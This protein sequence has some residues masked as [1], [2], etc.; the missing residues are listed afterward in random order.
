MP[1]WADATALAPDN[2]CIEAFE[3]PSGL[4]VEW[5]LRRLYRGGAPPPPHIAAEAR[6]ERTG[7]VLID[8]KSG[9]FRPAEASKL[10]CGAADAPTE[11]LGPH[12]TPAP[13]TLAFDRIGER[14]F[15]LK[16]R[17]RPGSVVE[18]VLEAH[19]ARD[20]AALWATPLLQLEATRPPPLRQ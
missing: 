12:A 14:L 3:G 7:A 9:R 4:R 8:L 19:D 20:G 16:R 5:R 13:D 18:L 15:A 2:V 6:D 1:D 17:P 11:G 10:P